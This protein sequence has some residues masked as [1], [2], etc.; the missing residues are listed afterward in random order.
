M[1]VLALQ[2]SIVLL[3]I[4]VKVPKDTKVLTIRNEAGVETVS[5]LIEINVGGDRLKFTVAGVWARP[6]SRIE[7]S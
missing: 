7:S 1:R 6:L 3:D 4:C 2:P 5:R